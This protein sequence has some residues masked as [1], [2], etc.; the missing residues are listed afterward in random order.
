[1]KRQI[2]ISWNGEETT[3][4]LSQGWNELDRVTKL[5]NL[6]D[7]IA[8]LTDLYNSMLAKPN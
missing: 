1:M 4:T 8:D 2:T 5:D 3:V 6:Q 7:A